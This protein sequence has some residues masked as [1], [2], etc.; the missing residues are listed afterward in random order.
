MIIVNYAEK[1]TRAKGLHRKQVAGPEAKR[2][3][4]TRPDKLSTFIHLLSKLTPLWHL[5]FW[6][7]FFLGLLFFGPSFFGSTFFGSTFFWF[8]FFSSTHDRLA[9][10]LQ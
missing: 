5:V 9:Y 4:K 3:G 1:E 8:C 2:G 6:A 7:F 10:Y